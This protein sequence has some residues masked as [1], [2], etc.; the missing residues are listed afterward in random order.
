MIGATI[1]GLG[2]RIAADTG[3]LD[4]NIATSNANHLHT[5]HKYDSISIGNQTRQ[6]CY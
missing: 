5:R 4:T 1:E 2:V 6:C 3:T